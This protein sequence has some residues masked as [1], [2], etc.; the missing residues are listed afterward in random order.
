MSEEIKLV[1]DKNAIYE[2]DLECLKK[3]KTW[4][5]ENSGEDKEEDSCGKG[6]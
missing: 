4:E 1:I 6:N 3:R 5:K 2:I